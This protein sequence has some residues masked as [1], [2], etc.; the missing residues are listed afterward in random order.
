MS[1]DVSRMTK[2]ETAHGVDVKPLGDEGARPRMAPDPGSGSLDRT[3][4][5]TRPAEVV[6]EHML[7]RAQ[8]SALILE[9]IVSLL[10]ATRG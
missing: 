1:D 8:C 2:H 7:R 9:G 5:V 3:R 10:K 6:V 4:E